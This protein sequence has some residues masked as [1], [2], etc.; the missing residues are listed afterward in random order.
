MAKVL[1]ASGND[2]EAFWPSMFAKAL[3]GQNVEELLSTIGSA[4]VA[5]APVAEAA[6]GKGEKKK[7][8]KYL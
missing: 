3:K 2:V 6:A 1:K 5:A 7:E 4:A 8:G